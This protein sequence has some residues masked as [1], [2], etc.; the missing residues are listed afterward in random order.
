MDV[1]RLDEEGAQLVVEDHVEAEDLEAAEAGV[2]RA[3][4]AREVRVL[5]VRL[6]GDE[7]LDHQL[8]DLLPQRVHVVAQPAQRLQQRGDGALVRR[9]VVHVLGLHRGMHGGVAA[10]GA[11]QGCG[12]SSAE[13]RQCCEQCGDTEDRR[14]RATGAAEVQS[15]GGLQTCTKASE[16][17][18]IE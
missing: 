18:L 13:R 15:Y 11:V 4:P 6:H 8:A 10:P 16:S 12:G 1:A 5:E 9:V 3:L 7:R 2:V 14:C 17:L